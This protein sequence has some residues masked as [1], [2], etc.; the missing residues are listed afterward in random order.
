MTSNNLQ[1][2]IVGD[3][4][5]KQVSLDAIVD[6]KSAIFKPDDKKEDNFDLYTHFRLGIQVSDC[7]QVCSSTKEIKSLA[8]EKSLVKREVVGL[9]GS[10][11]YYLVHSLKSSPD[12]YV[13]S[14]NRFFS[15]CSATLTASQF[16]LYYDWNK[17]SYVK[18][19]K[20]KEG[21]SMYCINRLAEKIGICKSS[22]LYWLYLPGCENC[23]DMYPEEIIAICSWKVFK[24]DTFTAGSDLIEALKS[25]SNK[26]IKRGVTIA[27]FNIKNMLD[28]FKELTNCVQADTGITRATE[29]YDALNDLFSSL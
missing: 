1:Y 25:L 15:I 7:E 22:I 10:F 27:D 19:T 12:N 3:N 8:K 5:M 16:G 4:V 6:A 24:H 14:P 29:L 26:L 18:T 2:F 21:V 13:M 9:K 20:S 17:K 11:T 28:H 23:F